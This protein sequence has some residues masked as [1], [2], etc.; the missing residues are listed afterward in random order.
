MSS[1]SFTQSRCIQLRPTGLITMV[2][3][4][5]SLG[6]CSEDSTVALIEES[7]IDYPIY[8]GRIL[9]KNQSQFDYLELYAYPSSS[10]PL[11]PEDNLIRDVFRSGEQMTIEVGESQYLTAIRPRV[12]DGPLWKIKTNQPVTFYKEEGGELPQLWI[13]DQGFMV[14]DPLSE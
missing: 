11:R 2:I 9:V 3:F 4:L 7:P 5:F 10:A 12:E 8:Y 14:I 13:L 6:G 1:Y